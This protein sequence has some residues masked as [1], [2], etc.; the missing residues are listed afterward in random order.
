MTANTQP[1]F[2]LTPK[3]ASAAIANADGQTQK[4]IYT[5]GVNGGR[6]A[7]LSLVSS[8]T[9]NRDVGIFVN[10]TL[11]C[12]IAVPLG[13]GTTGVLPTKDVLSDANCQS[14]YFDSNGNLVLDLPAAATLAINAPVSVTA[15][16]TI[17]GNVTAA[18]F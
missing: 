17:T 1:I 4:T 10:G 3:F 12:T 13:A 5:A 11:I 14:S 7:K 9:S 18:D 6:V 15:G 16:K 2:P 8:D